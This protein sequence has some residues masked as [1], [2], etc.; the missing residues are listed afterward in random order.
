M[1]SQFKKF[2]DSDFYGLIVGIVEEEIVQL[3]AGSTIGGTTFSTL[4]LTFMREG[5]VQ[6]LQNLIKRI[7]YEI[8]Q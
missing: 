8:E 6:A 3:Q 1:S 5:G 2:Y 4:K 7:D